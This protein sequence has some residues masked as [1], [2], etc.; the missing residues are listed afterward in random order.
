MSI[1]TSYLVWD[2]SYFSD[3]DAR[4]A[5]PLEIPSH[6]LVSMWITDTYTSASGFDMDLNTVHQSFVAGDLPAELPP[7]TPTFVS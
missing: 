6:F 2:K 5:V 4:P 1:V 7:Q 3:A